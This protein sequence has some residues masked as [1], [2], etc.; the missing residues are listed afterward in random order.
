MIRQ[1]VRLIVQ[2]NPG[3]SRNKRALLRDNAKPRGIRE[4]V[5]K[6]DSSQK[7]RKFFIRTFRFGKL[8][9]TYIFREMFDVCKIDIN[10]FMQLSD[11]V[12]NRY[13]NFCLSL[14]INIIFFI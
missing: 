3:V 9:G 2:D 1:D 7:L 5:R 4:Q 11:I 14:I 8:V 12:F 13:V 6:K 10:I